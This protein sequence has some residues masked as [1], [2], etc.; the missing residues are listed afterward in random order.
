MEVNIKE[1]ERI[2]DLE[3]ENLRLIQ[4]PDWFCFGIDSVL[5]SDYAKEIKNGAKVIDNN[6]H[7][8]SVTRTVTV[9]EP[10]LSGLAK[11]VYDDQQQLYSAPTLNSSSN[12]ANDNSGLYV[13]NVT[14]GFSNEVNGNTYYFRGNV[15][16]NYV[17]FAGFTWRII[18][19]NEDGTVRLIMTESINNNALYKFN[20]TYDADTLYYSN[21][22]V[23]K[24]ALDNWYSSNI[25]NAGY[26]SYV[27]NGY[28]CEEL[29]VT[30]SNYNSY[31]PS[32]NCHNNADGKG[33][34]SSKIGLIT[35]DEVI[36]AGGFYYYNND[37]I[38]DYYLNHSNEFWTMTPV[39]YVNNVSNAWFVNNE[40]KLRSSGVKN[41]MVLYPVI[42]I[43]SS[44]NF[45]KNSSNYY[46]I[47]N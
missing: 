34:F 27:A 37:T 31:V 45:T 13:M 22:D 6:G 35:Y 8:N 19:I 10:V 20:S 42:N 1:N 5:L 17:N 9:T 41:D 36:F 40:N 14:G 43:S 15:N 29:K 2:D 12:N 30:L 44:S 38:V 23:A 33:I 39:N 16:N 4:N 21:S 24:Q 28:F 18:R 47:S 46:V 3:Y 11:L 26:D 32:F 25:V 7:V